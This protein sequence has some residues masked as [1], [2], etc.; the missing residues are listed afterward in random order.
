M[1]LR[2]QNGEVRRP[3]T[4][5]SRLLASMA[6]I[7]LVGISA[8][9]GTWAAFTATTAN[10]GDRFESGSVAIGDND[11]GSTPMLSLAAAIPGAT[12]TGCIKVTYTGSLPSTVRLY[13]TT[14]GTGLDQYLDLKVTR[15]TYTPSD[16]GFDSCTNFQPDATEY[17]VGKGNGVVYD[18]TLQ[19]FPDSYAGGVVNPTAGTPES[20]TNNEVHVY[21]VQVTLQNNLAAENKNATQSFTWEAQSQ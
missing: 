9:S 8:G 20:W 19:G 3:V 6:L 2:R 12:D 15:G 17:I 7:S 21:K 11:G 5:R 18:G 4:I 16:P 10:G 14:T 1:R 13:G